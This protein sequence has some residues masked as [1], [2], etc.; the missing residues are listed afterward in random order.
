MPFLFLFTDDEDNVEA[1]GAEEEDFVLELVMK[2][3]TVAVDVLHH[4]SST[5]L[6]EVVESTL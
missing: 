4:S 6:V 1:G 3:L 5:K 2:K